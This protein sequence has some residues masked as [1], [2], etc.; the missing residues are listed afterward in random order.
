MAKKSPASAGVLVNPSTILHPKKTHTSQYTP[1]VLVYPNSNQ[2]P[3]SNSIES[4]TYRPQTSTLRPPHD[5]YLPVSTAAPPSVP[6]NSIDDQFKEPIAVYLPAST[7]APSAH[8]DFGSPIAVYDTTVKPK[9]LAAVAGYNGYNSESSYE[10]VSNDLDPP[11]YQKRYSMTTYR[12]SLAERP[13]ADQYENQLN[14][15]SLYNRNSYQRPQSYNQNSYGYGQD[16]S[17]YDGVSTTANGFKYYLPRQ[18]H[19]ED[20]SNPDRRAGSFG[21]ID[22]FGIRRVVYYNTSPEG[23]FQ[24]RKN[25]RYVGFNAT[26]YDPRPT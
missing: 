1:N 26:P 21:Y 17:Y 15:Q 7:P 5:L 9:P 18:Y 14:A 20:N 2:S 10:P 12:P 25:N 24:H 6:F 11:F 4:T 8:A 3:Y 22:P 13:Y 23:G 19:E 16:A